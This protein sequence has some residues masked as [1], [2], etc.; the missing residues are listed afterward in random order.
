MKSSKTLLPCPAG[1]MNCVS[2]AATSSKNQMSPLTYTGD[3]KVAF[4]RLKTLIEAL[5]RTTLIDGHRDYLHFE[6]KTRFGGFIDDVEFRL[7]EDSS[8]IDFRSASRVG[9]SDL[10]ANR[11][12]MKRIQRMWTEG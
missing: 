11:R 6:F 1:S 7:N 3:G 4:A 9:K 5:P 8:Q 10:G 12:R 2:T